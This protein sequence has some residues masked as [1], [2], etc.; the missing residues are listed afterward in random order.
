MNEAQKLT[1]TVKE[2][3]PF[4]DQAPSFLGDH[5]FRHHPGI[6][7]TDFIVVIERHV[8]IMMLRLK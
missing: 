1:K 2:P 8:S 3:K 4:W 5:V 6:S 7:R